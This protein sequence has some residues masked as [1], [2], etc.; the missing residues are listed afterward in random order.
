MN[1]ESEPRTCLLILEREGCVV[2]VSTAAF[3]VAQASR[4]E[5][6]KYIGGLV[7]ERDGTVK[8]IENIQ[9]LGAWGA[10]KLRRMLSIL[11]SAWRIHT[12]FSPPLQ[13]Q[14]DQLRLCLV[15]LES[16]LP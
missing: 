10:T 2:P 11:T 4:R 15:E 7:V 3:T 8:R 5:L 1:L 13:M 9:V 6:T 16:R 14:F 12:V